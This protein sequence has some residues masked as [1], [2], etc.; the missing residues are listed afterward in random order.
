MLVHTQ[1]GS[2]LDLGDFVLGHTQLGSEIDPPVSWLTDF[3]SRPCLVV[4]TN[5]FCSSAMINSE[6]AVQDE[7]NTPTK[8]PG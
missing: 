8:Q 2:E 4:M 6:K 7:Q 1:L 3:L 5:P